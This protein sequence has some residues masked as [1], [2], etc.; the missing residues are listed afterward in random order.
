MSSS[1]NGWTTVR[2]GVYKY[3]KRY[4]KKRPCDK[5]GKSLPCYLDAEHEVIICEECYNIL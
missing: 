5:C 1:S 2:G 3:D 4:F